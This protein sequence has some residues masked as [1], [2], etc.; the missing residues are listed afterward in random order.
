MNNEYAARLNSFLP[1][2][3]QLVAFTKVPQCESLLHAFDRMTTWFRLLYDVRGSEQTAVLIAAAHSKVIEIWILIP[4]GLMHSAYTALRTFVDICTSYTFYSSHPIEWE[5]VCED[6][7]N[8]EG[9]AD[10][11]EWNIKFAPKCREM[12][13]AFGLS[14]I[15]NLNY[16][17]LSAFVHGIPVSGLPALKSIDK[18]NVLDEDLDKF[19][20]LANETS[21]SLNL[22]FLSVF[23]EELTSL[24]TTDY[25]TI[26]RG[27][28]RR[29]LGD[30]GIHLPRV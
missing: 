5:A 18:V 25:R 9:R 30:V 10:I 22:L 16:Q 1:S 11:I 4:L 23:H 20:R 27:L 28:D 29:K 7:A 19:T 14:E 8:W 17:H 12:N 13:R 26:T 21:E 15:L 24:S 6:R 3:E 2:E